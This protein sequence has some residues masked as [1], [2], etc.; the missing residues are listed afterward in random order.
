AATA[1][2]AR[3]VKAGL[4]T[5]TF[6]PSPL[7][8]AV[9]VAVLSASVAPIPESESV[10]VKVATTFTFRQP[11]AFASGDALVYAT[12]GAV[13]SILKPSLC[14]AAAARVLP[15]RSVNAGES[16]FTAD[17]SPLV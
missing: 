4:S 15:A 8:V 5:V 9:S 6:A 2:P 16:A 10:A 1:F 12:D 13:L 3:S 14:T 17:P 7:V 11:F